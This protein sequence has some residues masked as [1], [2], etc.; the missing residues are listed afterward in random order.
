MLAG[1]AEFAADIVQ[2]LYLLFRE[3]LRSAELV[4]EQQK[5]RVEVNSFHLVICVQQGIAEG[6]R[7]VILKQ[8]RV[9]MLQ[10]RLYRVRDLIR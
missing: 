3:L 6:Q 8:Y 9:K 10:E 2:T 1:H 4:G 7:S 5:L